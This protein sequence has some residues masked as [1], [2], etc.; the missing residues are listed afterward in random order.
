MDEAEELARSV[1]AD[2]IAETY[3]S[4]PNALADAILGRMRDPEVGWSFVELLAL[5][6][7]ADRDINA[8]GTEEWRRAR[9]RGI[10]GSE[11]SVLYGCNPWMNEHALWALKT[12]RVSPPEVTIQTAPSL[13]WGTAL[14][15]VVRRGYQ[16]LTGR[17]VVE[18]DTLLAHPDVPVLLANT[19]GTLIDVE[20]RGGPG[21]YEGKTASV[22]ARRE[23]YTEDGLPS[24]PL[25]YQVQV[26]HYL[27]CTGYSWASLAVYFGGDRE[28]LRFFDVERHDALIDDLLHR[29]ARWWHDH[30][31]LDRP[32]NI[33]AL[34]Q[35]ESTLRAMRPRDDGSIVLLPDEFVPVLDRLAALD[36]LMG[37]LE[38][39]KQ[40]CRNLVI[41]TLG[42][43]AY[44]Q[45]YDGRGFTFRNERSSSGR[46]L[47]TASEGRM[48]RA[49][50]DTGINYPPPAYVPPG[51]G[52]QLAQIS[53][54]SWGITPPQPGRTKIDE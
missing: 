45:V 41:A 5:E 10:G 12:G 49:R 15:P 26:Q 40:R 9:A 6:R 31:E 47:R 38:A 20:G 30:V 27:A 46:V 35:T 43:A 32:P 14:E 13:Y 22:F 51:V 48:K 33:D 11:A 34:P 39:E 50:R 1:L 4:G 16:D 3:E 53:S 8:Q 54:I 29:A 21:V 17:T 52:E 36:V 18:G 44:G 19:D 28:P 7:I 2:A 37:Q 42:D 24:I 25:H 23:W